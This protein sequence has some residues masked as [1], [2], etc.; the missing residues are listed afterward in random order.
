MIAS[1]PEIETTEPR[2]STPTEPGLAD[3]ADPQRGLVDVPTPPTAPPTRRTV[4]ML[5]AC[6]ALAR[7]LFSVQVRTF[8]MSPDEFANAGMSRFL[9]GGHFDMLRTNT[10]RPGYPTLLA[11]VSMLVDDPSWWVRSALA[12]NAVVAGIS[13]VWLVKIVQRLTRLGGSATLAV[14]GVI[15]LAPASMSASGHVWAE[16]LVTLAFLGALWSL[17]RFFDDFRVSAGLAAVT[18][19]VF[20][21][22][23]HGR[24][25]PLLGMSTLVVVGALAWRRNWIGSVLVGGVSVGGALLTN[26]YANWVYDNV[27]TVVGSTNTSEGVLSRLAHPLQVLDAAFGQI[28]YQLAASALVFGVGL[29]VLIASAFAPGRNSADRTDARLT[30]ALTVPMILMSVTFMS[31]RARGD[32][33]VYGRYSDA[34]VWPVLAVGAAWIVR[35]SRAD[36]RKLRLWAFV[37]V[38]VIFAEFALMLRQ[39]HHRQLGSGTAVIDMIPGFMPVIDGSGAIPVLMLSGVALAV[40]SAFVFA[41]RRLEHR[42]ALLLAVVLG[43]LVAADVAAYVHFPSRENKWEQ[44]RE[45]VPFVEENIPAGSTIGVALMPD[46]FGPDAAIFAQVSWA[47]AYQWYLPD[48]RFTI[49]AGLRDDVGPYIVATTNDLILSKNGGTTLW[50]QPDASMAFW[51]EPDADAPQATVVG[52]PAP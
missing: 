43:A 19:G 4:L 13:V 51:L 35:G 36:S 26:V 49:D 40:F 7:F 33:V 27:W 9:A 14:A 15:A 23:C 44:A 32:Q 52:P 21:Y 2:L 38:P 46:D 28:W 3:S 20:G 16:P 31:D 11:P 18:W 22:L 45:A 48:Y 41:S 8:A 17:M 42:P 34:I 37:G 39:L 25:L 12:V 10:W 47:L 30:L 50:E 29:L 5:A 6:V 24:L 1:I